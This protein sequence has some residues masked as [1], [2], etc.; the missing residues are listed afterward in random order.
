M[1]TAIFRTDASVEIGGGHVMRCL[2][3]ADQLK[4]NQWRTIFL[5]RELRGN[6]FGTIQ[7]RGHEVQGLP[8][9][10]VESWERDAKDV[11]GVL[12]Q[13]GV[14]P[15][16]LIVDHYSL[17]SRWERELQASVGKIMVVDDNA[18]RMHDCDLLLDQNLLPKIEESYRKVVPARTQLLLGPQY[19]LLA[20]DYEVARQRV[21][22]HSGEVKRI[23]IS[24]GSCDPSN[25]TGKALSALAAIK[26]PDIRIDVVV[27]SANPNMSGVEKQMQK[28]PNSYLHVQ[29]SSLAPLIQQADLALS[30]GGSTIYELL[31]L[32][33]PIVV[34]T[35]ADNQ[36]PT[37]RHLSSLEIVTWLGCHRDVSVDHVQMA[38]EKAIKN[39]ET[40][41]TKSKRG[42]EMMVGD[43]AKKV[44]AKMEGCGRSKSFKIG[45]VQIGRDARP[46]IIAE[47]SG[48]HNQSLERALEIVRA[49]AKTGAQALKL[50]TYTADTLTLDVKGNGFFI[51]DE[52]SLWKGKSL[53]TLYQEAHT[54]WEWH[55][56]IMKLANEL[57][58]ICFSTPFDETAVDF[59][60]SLNVPCYKIA[61]FENT[62]IPLIRKVA[63]TQKPIIISTGMATVEEIQEAV[64]TIRKNGGKDIV[65]LKCT[66]SYPAKPDDSNI[67]TMVDMRERFGC[68]VGLS[69]HTMGI[70]AACAAVA[71]GATV[72][73]KHFTLCRA[74][75]GV[76]SAFSLEP[77]EMQALVVETD[78]AWRAL[79]KVSY[80]SSAAEK[81][82]LQERRSLYVATDMKAGDAFTTQN[83]KC[84]RPGFGL[85][86]KHYDSLLGQK[87]I[88]DANKGTPVSWAL[89]SGEKMVLN[90]N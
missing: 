60:E 1:K 19:A 5:C 10:A 69:D 51:D 61:S 4:A 18:E 83:L 31:I 62:H 73:E 67:M 41:I 66:S 84:I 86:P 23:L 55:A 52:N 74:D 25:E 71:H 3:L 20:T 29:L 28:L 54:P 64:D 17:D 44:V 56:P 9:G 38:I 6:L 12:Q 33:V 24:Y 14:R 34:T 75:G 59:L 81:T 63:Q 68:E 21:K 88:C 48:N 15:E 76:D 87:I 27:G 85:A 43:G 49:A 36:L 39:P 42:C 16:W 50:Q 78:I 37:I 22:P 30:A 35:T 53:Y 13:L 82:S 45:T 40:I 77:A 7:A 57:G 46:F 26:R 58:M 47:M 70:G 90:E 2:V 72:V 89:V 32:G 65:L 79:G 80:G 8:G 11:E